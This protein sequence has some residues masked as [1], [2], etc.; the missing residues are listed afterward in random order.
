MSGP[1][2]DDVGGAAAPPDDPLIDAFCD[3]V[4]LEDGL[5]RS[6]LENYRR[7]LRQL[8]GRLPPGLG[9]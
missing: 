5:A 3:R 6:S 8:G 4:W 9:R 1:A 2:R 7:D